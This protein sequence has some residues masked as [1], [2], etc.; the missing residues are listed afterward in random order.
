M[1]NDKDYSCKIKQFDG[2]GKGY[3]EIGKIFDCH[4]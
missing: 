3:G 1:V 4:S 2:D